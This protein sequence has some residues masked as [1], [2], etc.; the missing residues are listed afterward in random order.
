MYVMFYCVFV[1]FPYGVLCQ[2]WRLI[3]SI[4]DLC[5]LS[6]FDIDIPTCSVILYTYIIVKSIALEKYR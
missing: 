6:H 5:L 4:P 3:V 2:V 1:T